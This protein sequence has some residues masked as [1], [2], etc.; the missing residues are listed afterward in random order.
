MHIDGLFYNVKVWKC[1]LS[2]WQIR[3]WHNVIV[4]VDVCYVFAPFQALDQSQMSLHDKK[5]YTEVTAFIGWWT[6]SETYKFIAGCAVGVFLD[7]MY[8][9]LRTMWNLRVWVDFLGLVGVSG[10]DH[11]PPAVHGSLSWQHH[12]VCWSTE[13]IESWFYW[14]IYTRKVYIIQKVILIMQC[15]NDKLKVDI[16]CT[17]MV[18]NIIVNILVWNMFNYSEFSIQRHHWFPKKWLF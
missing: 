11:G 14:H 15:R 6:P 8:Y 1:K 13:N 2:K 4:V 17:Q 10:S 7:K 12:E 18:Y 5:R 3:I 16:T 9:S